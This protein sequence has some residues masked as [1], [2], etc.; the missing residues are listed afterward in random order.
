MGFNKQTAFAL[1]YPEPLD[2]VDYQNL[3]MSG[4]RRVQMFYKT[5]L[6]LPR[7]L[8]ELAQMGVGVT[9]RLEEP[10]MIPVAESYYNAANH[11]S[12]KAGVEQIK[13]RVAVEAVIVGNEPEHPYKLVWGERWGNNPDQE[14]PNPGG[15]AQAHADAVAAITP[16][17][18]GAA[19]RVVSPGWTHKRITPRD[20]PEPGRMSWRELTLPAYNACDG[21]GAHVYAHSWVS[22]EDEN[23]FLWAL[24]E[25][26]A[27]CHKAVWLNETNVRA[28]GLDPV[29]RMRCVRQ[30]A[31]LIAQRHVG[32]HEV[33]FWH[34]G[35]RV[36]S[37]CPFVSNGRPDEE[38]SPMII[39][40]PQA[41]FELGQWLGN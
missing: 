33:P 11:A 26:I 30:M 35:G 4:V 36:V 40:H 25:E 20:R 32:G 3:R 23:R 41:Y 2:N 28:G 27:R 19:V 34:D 14:F 7:Q 22:P 12:I 8:E 16:V 18:K 37:F 13:R 17:L 38:W 39:R 10:H 9:L 1:F 21:N 29:A 5:A 31:D 24:G 6:V 15:R